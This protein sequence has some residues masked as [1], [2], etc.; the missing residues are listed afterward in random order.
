MPIRD[1]YRPVVIPSSKRGFLLQHEAIA[2]V[3]LLPD[4]FERDEELGVRTSANIPTFVEIIGGSKGGITIAVPLQKYMDGSW[5]ALEFGGAFL[6]NSLSL[7]GSSTSMTMDY[8]P[9][10]VFDREP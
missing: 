6:F 4:G 3:N 9:L 8:R 1:V 7:S 2:S 10:P 5:V